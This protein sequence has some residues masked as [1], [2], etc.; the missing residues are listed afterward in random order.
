MGKKHLSLVIVPHT[1]TSYRTLS[2]S[3]RVVK[4]AVWGSIAAGVILLGMT[5]D[6]V[7]LKFRQHNF[8]SLV[9]EN[10]KNKKDISEKDK[11]ITDLRDRLA[12]MDTLAKKLSIVAG[13]S[14][15]TD[16]IDALGPGGPTVNPKEGQNLPGP[17]TIPVTGTDQALRFK[18]EDI[19]KKIENLVN[20]FQDKETQL[21]S[22]PSIY[23]TRGLL[24]S[25]FQYRNDPFT[26]MRTFH[27]GMDIAAAPGNPIVATADGVVIQAV[28][29]NLML[30]NYVIIS[31]GLGLITKYGHMSKIRAVVGQKV[32][33]GDIIGEVG[34][35]G[36]AIGPHVHYEVH[37]NGRPVNPYYYILEE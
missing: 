21:A 3:K 26:G 32:R 16:I 20:F 1:K 17:L 35:T 13:I 15:E 27:F 36:K 34:A 33:R 5:V 24:T 12:K 11:T 19:Q 25:A 31:H 18:A 2:F 29:H 6:Y 30:G 37:L 4:G 23:P 7:F 8:N 9:S 22:T 14:A 10:A 28:P